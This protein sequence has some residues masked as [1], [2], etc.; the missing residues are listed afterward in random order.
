MSKRLNLEG[1]K[2]GRLL[3]KEYYGS[4]LRGQ[5]LWSCLCDCGKMTVVIAT[6]LKCGHTQSCG[7]LR[8]EMV[9]KVTMKNIVGQKFNRLLVTGRA[10][11][12]KDGRITWFCLCDCG[13]TVIAS[14][15]G[16]RNGHTKSCG[17]WAY[18][19][20]TI[21]Q[22]GEKSHRWKGGLSH[23]NDII[24]KSFEY[25]KWRTS[26]FERDNYTCQRC[27]KRSEKG[28]SVILNA[29]HIKSFCDH[30]EL[31]LDV[32]NGETLCISCHKETDNYCTNSKF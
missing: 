17:C 32:N 1:E 2:I 22:K 9:S 26:V 19:V 6:D 7:C 12:T 8:Y 5:A 13:N 16:L 18:H 31:R 25:K 14:G 29:H 27:H 28:E 20:R 4:N 24:R 15:K 11:T 23:Q 21:L 3:V 10:S 30:E